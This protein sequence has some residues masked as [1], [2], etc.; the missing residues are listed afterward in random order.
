HRRTNPCAARQRNSQKIQHRSD[1]ALVV[2]AEFLVFNAE[3]ID[4]DSLEK[5][6]PSFFLSL[7]LFETLLDQFRVELRFSLNRFP[8]LHFPKTSL[9]RTS[10]RQRL[11]EFVASENMYKSKTRKDI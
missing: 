5:A 7:A 11:S 4:A 3:R 9:K 2:L 10:C 8:L 1:G 6:L